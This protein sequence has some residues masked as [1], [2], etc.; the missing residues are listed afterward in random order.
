V[1][2]VRAVFITGTDTGV[3]K[4]T[5]A[6]LLARAL[7]EWGG[8]SVLKPFASGNTADARQLGQAAGVR[9]F[10]DITV[11]FCHRP[12]APAAV[13]GCG[14]KAGRFVNKKIDEAKNRL[15]ERLKSGDRVVVEGLGGVLAPL[16][17]TLTVADLMKSFAVPVWLVARPGLGTLNHSLL[18]LEV[19]R[20]RGVTV[21]RLVVSGVGKTFVEQSNL[22][23]LRKLCAVPVTALP[24]LTSL[25]KEIQSQRLLARAFSQ[26]VERLS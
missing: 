9:K 6:V 5:V 21:K 26:D 12:V 15:D 19:L 13:L 11:H 3:G 20:H 14:V 7:R 16:G 1:F 23:I 10:S 18:S 25:K 4:T 17:G 8:V 2:F 22:S 24:R